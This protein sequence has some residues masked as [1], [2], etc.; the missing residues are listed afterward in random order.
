MAK[1]SE[2][3]AAEMQLDD[4]E[5]IDAWV[6]SVIPKVLDM[7]FI[8]FVLKLWIAPLRGARWVIDKHL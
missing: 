5:R 7:Q 8:Q 1:V 2:T 4:D 6:V 3:P